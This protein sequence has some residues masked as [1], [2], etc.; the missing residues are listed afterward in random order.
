ME[1]EE[2][3][4]AAALKTF[5]HGFWK[6]LS[7]KRKLLAFTSILI[8]LSVTLVSILT[9]SRYTSYFNEQSTRQTEQ[10]LEQIGIN[11]DTYVDELFR[12]SVSPYYNSDIMSALETNVQTDLEK[13]EKRRIIENF[14]SGVMTI[15]RNDILRVYIVTED[16]TYSSN[17]TNYDVDISVDN[18]NS[19]WYKQ[20]IATSSPVF[21]PVHKESA[22][23]DDTIRIFSIVQRL[24]STKDNSIILGAIKVDANYTGIK[25]ICDKV[26]LQKGSALFVIDKE[27]NIVYQNSQLGLGISG[28]SFFDKALSAENNSVTMNSGMEK[29]IVSSQSMQATD[30]Q[31]VKVNSV[32]AMNQYFTSTRNAAF[33]LAFIC[34]LFAVFISIFFVN[35]FLRPLFKI[36]N[37]MKQV[38]QGDLNARYEIKNHDEIGY[39]GESFN[40]MIGQIDN[41]MERN[42]Q[43]VKEVYEVKYLQKEAQYNALCSQIKPHFLYNTLNTINLLIKCNEP[44]KAVE[45]IGK[46]SFLLRGIMN[47][48]REITVADELKIV[49][50]YLSLQKSRYGNNLQYKIDIDDCYK[51][52][53]I[54]ALTLQPIVEN[55]VIH[56]CEATRGESF[57]NLYDSTDAD[58]LYFHIT[59][60][61]PGIAADKLSELQ[62]KLAEC[63]NIEPTENST[64][65]SIGLINVNRRIKLRYGEAYG[66]DIQSEIDHETHI[67]LHLPL[68][69]EVRR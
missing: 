56:G 11:L 44:Q 43:L 47:I 18:T 46:L 31:I 24:R 6:N 28:E 22:F 63:Q 17:K 57:I 50:A 4:E 40:Q 34:A 8:L 2:M 9:Y 10:I 64:S 45:D 69:S 20:A 5:T 37:L 36:V 13:L 49:D 33:I 60:N 35:S 16:G 32:S 52:Y 15:P 29:Y 66:I 25:S 3:K 12:L 42:T 62:I 41:M 67:T 21:L 1:N 65:N 59:D 68:H 14:L 38:Q 61:G 19:D 26:Q 58:S 48:D 27:K 51:D 7:L 53:L 54:P 39:L 55:A 23:R 30:W